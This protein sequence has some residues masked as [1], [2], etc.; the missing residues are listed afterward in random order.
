MSDIKKG[1]S[2]I[3]PLQLSVKSTF[4]SSNPKTRHSYSS[5]YQNS[6]FYL[7]GQFMEPFRPTWLVG[8]TCQSHVSAGRRRLRWRCGAE[9]RGPQRTDRHTGHLSPAPAGR[10]CHRPERQQPSTVALSAPPTSHPLT[11]RR[12]SPPRAA[13]TP[14]PRAPPAAIRRKPPTAAA[15]RTMPL[16]RARRRSRLQDAVP[17]PHPHATRHAWHCSSRRPFSFVASCRLRV[18]PWS[19]PSVLF[20]P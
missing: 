2:P 3:I 4:S 20:L 17:L 14:H 13:A 12:Q 19:F 1:R 6:L 8:P 15:R 16:A 9:V 7:P 11:T 5:N 10:A 18:L